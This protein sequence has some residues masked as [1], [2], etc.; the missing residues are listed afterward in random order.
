MWVKVVVAQQTVI[1][2]L[3]VSFDHF[4]LNLET[5]T[6]GNVCTLTELWF[7]LK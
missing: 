3:N 2:N 6:E 1:G 7:E 4:G 5:E